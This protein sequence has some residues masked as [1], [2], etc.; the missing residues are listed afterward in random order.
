MIM[1]LGGGLQFGN[2]GQFAYDGSAFAGFQDVILVST[3]Y[4]TNVFGFPNAPEVLDSE[5]NLGF[6]DQQLALQW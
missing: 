2:A 3:N 4:R 1:C 6:L 5:N